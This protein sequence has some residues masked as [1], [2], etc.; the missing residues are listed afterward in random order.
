MCIICMMRSYCHLKLKPSSGIN[1]RDTKSRHIRSAMITEGHAGE[2]K[3]KNRTTFYAR[4][5]HSYVRTLVT[6]MVELQGDILHETSI[7]VREEI[8]TT[9][10]C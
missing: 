2:T 10:F 1:D 3:R 9:F 7:R 8:E 5:E 6:F 4:Q